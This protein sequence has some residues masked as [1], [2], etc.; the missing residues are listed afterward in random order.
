LDIECANRRL[1]EEKKL[2]ILRDKEKEARLNDI[3]IKE[4]KK[5]ILQNKV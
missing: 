5:L 1:E 3:R 2:I 4:F